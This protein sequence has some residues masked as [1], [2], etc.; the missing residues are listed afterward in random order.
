MPKCE[1]RSKHIAIYD[2]LFITAKKC[3]CVCGGEATEMSKNNQ[4]NYAIWDIINN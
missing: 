3:V 4:I 2:S 1:P